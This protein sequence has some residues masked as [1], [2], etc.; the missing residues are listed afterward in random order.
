VTIKKKRVKNCTGNAIMYNEEEDELS[1]NTNDDILKPS[2]QVVFSDDIR[3]A[4]ETA[5]R[6]SRV[7]TAIMQIRVYL[8][9]RGINDLKPPK[10]Q[11]NDGR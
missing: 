8:S 11:P 1:L 10:Q 6:L 3:A 9:Q 2:I 5:Q 7:K 4:E